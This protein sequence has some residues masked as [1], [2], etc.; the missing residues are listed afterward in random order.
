[1]KPLMRRLVA[2][3][4]RAKAKPKAKPTKKAKMDKLA[5]AFAAAMQPQPQE[6]FQQVAPQQAQPIPVANRA[7]IIARALD[8]MQR[9]QTMNT[10]KQF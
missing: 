9:S 7:D 10:L 2:K 5:Q 8:M 6:T 4:L 1:M 3:T